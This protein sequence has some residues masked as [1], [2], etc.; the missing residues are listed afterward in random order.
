[1]QLEPL[2]KNK[3]PI[4]EK[5]KSKLAVELSK[6]LTTLIAIVGASV[7]GIFGVG[8]LFVPTV[9]AEIAEVS[10]GEHEIYYY[11]M[12]ENFNKDDEVYVVLYN[13]FTN[14]SQ[15]VDAVEYSDSPDYEDNQTV[16]FGGA[17]EDLQVDM[18]YTLAVK[19]GTYTITSMV[20]KTTSQRTKP[21]GANG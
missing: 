19:Q 4:N 6:I 2:E 9:R 17:F 10:V 7:A 11:V 12:I 8:F 13:D 3:L 5:P 15:K 20:L 21:S 1:M 18:T 16:E 14:R